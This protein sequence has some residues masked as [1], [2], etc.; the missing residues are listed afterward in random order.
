[1]YRKE[2]SM[3]EMMNGWVEDAKRRRMFYIKIYW[4]IHV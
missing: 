2:G 3:E 1:V 4:G